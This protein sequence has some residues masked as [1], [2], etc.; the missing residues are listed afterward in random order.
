MAI[1]HADAVMPSPPRIAVAGLVLLMRHAFVAAAALSYLSLASAWVACAACA[2]VA[3]G[4]AAGRGAWCEAGFLV[5]FASLKV[6]I[7]AAVLFGTLVLAMLLAV[8][9]MAGMGF[10]GF[11]FSSD[12]KKSFGPTKELISEL[13]HDTCVQRLLASLTFYL[14]SSVTC[15][16]IERLLPVKGS[17]GEEIG[18][19]IVTVWLLL[20]GALVV[21]CFVMVPTAALLIWRIMWTVKQKIE[22]IEAE[23]LLM[24]SPSTSAL[25]Q[26]GLEDTEATV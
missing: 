18:S 11:S 19:V 6:L 1:A 24:Y 16:V 17:Q 26:Q 7:L 20:L 12:A 25:K 4:F 8:C 15:L 10:L 13:L 2:V 22:E 23:L 9:G 21:S 14:I 3:V 5:A